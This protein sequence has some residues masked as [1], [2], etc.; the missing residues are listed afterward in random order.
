MNLTE[1]LLLVL[2]FINLI[3]LLFFL[4]NR[5]RNSVIDREIERRIVDEFAR[6]RLEYS[7][8]S[9]ELRLE[10]QELSKRYSDEVS[11]R[12]IEISEL[13]KKQM[14]SFSNH[15]FKFTESNEKSLERIRESVDKNMKNLQEENKEKLNEIKTIVGIELHS[16]LEKRLGEAFKQVSERLEKVHQGLGEMHKLA[17]GVGDLK[18]VLTNV[19]TRGIF[20]E[21]QLENQLEDVLTKDQFDKNVRVKKN[22]NQNVE[23][24]V[25]LPGK[26]KNDKPV[27]LPVD[28][29]FPMEFY[30]VLLEAY[31]AA[32]RE[33][34]DKSKKQFEREIKTFAK[35]IQEKYINP[36]TTT[37]FA[38]MYLPVEGLYAEVL[39]IPG[40]FHSL[41]ND[42]RIIPVGPTI[43]AAFLNSLSM[44]FKTLT[45]EKRSSDVWKLL[46]A[47]KTQFTKFGDLLDKTQKKLS[48][49]SSTIENASK[50]ARFIEGK[51][52]KVQ[53]IPAQESS[54]LLEDNIESKNE[55]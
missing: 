30:E 48:E 9:K 8:A 40:L 10:L 49:A 52:N 42:F 28:S 19:K 22:S 32:D 46:G 25:K 38:I 16:T 47:V 2:I 15:I 41:S 33:K 1:I 18:K 39:R 21:I 24:A 55:E 14:E 45:I 31:D 44:G 5:K 35:D 53:E 27:W 51:L 4:I 13:Q 6:N 11:K 7:K 12:I 23:F 54:H 17:T 3:F 36:P 43:L 37:D 20:G 26:G 29:K 50:K 34:I